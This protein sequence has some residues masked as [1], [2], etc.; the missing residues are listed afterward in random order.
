[1]VKTQTKSTTNNAKVLKR[2]SIARNL[3]LNLISGKLS[4]Q[5]LERVHEHRM[6][7]IKSKACPISVSMEEY[8]KQ[9]YV[10]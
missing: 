2:L 8:R 1:M 5:A 4:D 10:R 7:A 3:V 6:G 9:F